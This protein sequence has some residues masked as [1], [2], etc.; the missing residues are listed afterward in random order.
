M[1]IEKKESFLSFLN[2]ITQVKN[3]SGT[4]IYRP[5]TQTT[6]V[7]YRDKNVKTMEGIFI[8]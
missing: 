6:Q 5:R 1:P 8:F 4:T 7:M 2:N 3:D